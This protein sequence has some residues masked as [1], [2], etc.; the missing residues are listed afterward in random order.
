MRDDSTHDC[1]DIVVD[2]SMPGAYATGVLDQAARFRG[3]P[4][5]IRTDNGPAFTCEASIAWVQARGIKHILIQPGKPTQNACIESFNGKLRDEC[6][7]ENWFES[8]AQA[9]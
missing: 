5:V 3:Y 9:C 8:L 7:N 1:I 2:M 4:E 6:L